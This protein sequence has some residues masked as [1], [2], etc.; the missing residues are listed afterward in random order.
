MP[1]T[2]ELLIEEL[3]C[4]YQCKPTPIDILIVVRN[5]YTYVRDCLES[6]FDKTSDFH[7]FIWDN[8]SNKETADFLADWPDWHENVTL[9][10]SDENKGFITPNNELC[11][12]GKSPYIILLNSDT[13]VDAGWDT[14][15]IGHL[16]KHDNTAAV[17]Y[18]GWLLNAE[19]IGVMAWKGN[20]IDYV[21]AWALALPRKVY[22]D[23][24]LFDAQNL[25][26]GYAEDADYCLRAKEKGWT[27]YSLNLDLVKHH[28]NATTKHVSKERDL[29]PD[30]LKNHNYL[31]ERHAHYLANKRILL[32]HPEIEASMNAD[33][34]TAE[35]VAEIFDSW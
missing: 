24:G 11:A 32:K 15:L 26:F 1:T 4:Q 2:K 30:F 12:M 17:G 8:A 3:I 28:G 7:L 21:A 10:R 31:K 25:H 5:G 23:I 9:V 34:I 14:A 27:V 22:Q 29:R 20:E 16:Q 33:D 35:K 13:I 19:G 6:V 18:Q